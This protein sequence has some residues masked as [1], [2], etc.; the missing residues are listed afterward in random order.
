MRYEQALKAL[1]EGG[2]IRRASWEIGRKL[3]YGPDERRDKELIYLIDS[4]TGA[5]WLSR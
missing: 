3:T 4:A 2:S 5:A 1:K